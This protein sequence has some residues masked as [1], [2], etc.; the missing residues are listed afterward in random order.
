[1]RFKRA[2]RSYVLGTTAPLDVAV[3]DFLVVEADRGEDLGVVT[4][5]LS[6][7]EFIERRYQQQQFL[8]GRGGRGGGGGGGGGGGVGGGGGGGTEDD[9][10]SVGRILRRATASERQHLPEKFHDEQLVVQV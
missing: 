8:R 4:D 6:M 7:K 2:T 3:G 5:I 9:D 1:M 10:Q